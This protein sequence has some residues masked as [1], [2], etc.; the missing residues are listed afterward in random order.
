MNNK[1]PVC[2][3]YLEAIITFTVLNLFYARNKSN[4]SLCPK[5][6]YQNLPMQRL[7]TGNMNM[8]C[9]MIK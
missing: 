6:V 2:G 9:T 8:N 1:L 7:D 3:Y 5:C 4:S